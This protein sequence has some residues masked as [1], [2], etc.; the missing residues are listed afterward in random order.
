M[1]QGGLPSEQLS[2]MAVDDVCDM[3]SRLEG[4]S[5]LILPQYLTRIRESNISGIVLL[6]CDMGELKPVMQMTFGDWELFRALVQALREREMRR[7]DRGTAGQDFLTEAPVSPQVM[8][9]QSAPANDTSVEVP[10]AYYARQ[11]GS[12]DSKTESDGSQTVFFNDSADYAQKA[13]PGQRVRTQP[14][15]M[16]R[17]MKEQGLG[18][19]GGAGV[20][21][22]PRVKRIDSF[23]GE[24]MM[25][26]EA[27]RGFIEA[28]GVRTDS[29]DSDEEDTLQMISPISEEDGCI[30]SPKDGSRQKEGK[31]KEDRRG[32]KHKAA[33][34]DYEKP[35]IK[36]CSGS[37]TPDSDS[38]EMRR[39][40]HKVPQNSGLIPKIKLSKDR[41]LSNHTLDLE[42]DRSDRES[43]RG[44][45]D[46]ASRKAA[47]SANKKEGEKHELVEEGSNTRQG[48][49]KRSIKGLLQ[50]IRRGLSKENVTESEALLTAHEMGHRSTDMAGACSEG[51][52]STT[53]SRPVSQGEHFLDLS[54]TVASLSDNI[55]PTSS[56]EHLALR[57]LAH[58]EDSTGP[59]A[60]RSVT[61]PSS[62]PSSRASSRAPS[63]C[64]SAGIGRAGMVSRESSEDEDGGL[65]LPRDSRPTSP[66]KSGSSRASDTRDDTP[67]IKEG[68]RGTGNRDR[69]GELC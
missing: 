41:H 37:D 15:N 46:K 5:Q 2:S 43:N 27:L 68:N 35:K 57:K 39:L 20:K 44:S 21:L 10:K 29:E 12:S 19:Q 53:S 3:L 62:L 28:T 9:T 69:A 64:S 63:H 18:Q 67:L 65:T 16:A 45:P 38:E 1:F 11:G 8:F 25:E 59:S 56:Y 52:D 22:N 48:S 31:R 34:L 40:Y 47:S 32:G 17:K 6:N 50:K 55:S 54:D 23:V 42:S 58:S 30:A 51:P 66:R 13:L 33:R 14:S 4:L 49:Q 61:P 26:S 36:G 24:V 7:Q 60:F